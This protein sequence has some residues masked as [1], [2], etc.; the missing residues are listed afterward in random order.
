M[1]NLP[2]DPKTGKPLRGRDMQ[3]EFVRLS[4]EAARDPEAERAFIQS[5][6]E[7]IESDTRLSEDEKAKAIAELQART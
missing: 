7:A 5:K 2:T 3:A 6:I 4:K 1:E